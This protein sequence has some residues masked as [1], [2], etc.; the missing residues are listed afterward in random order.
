MFISLDLM[1]L[2][3][4]TK[5]HVN[6]YLVI[7]L[8]DT[9][10]IWKFCKSPLLS[11]LR[12]LGYVLLRCILIFRSPPCWLL[13]LWLPLFAIPPSHGACSL[14]PNLCH[15]KIQVGCMFSN[16]VM[17][18]NYGATIEPRA[19]LWSA[20]TWLCCWVHAGIEVVSY[21]PLQNYTD[22]LFSHEFF[23]GYLSLSYLKI[24]TSNQM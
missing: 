21:D 19:S 2:L 22:V 15:M 13:T 20:G 14:Q 8:V 17:S 5:S 9:R 16:G 3:G 6:P 10:R 7:T 4:K 12:Q 24:Y 18:S 1:L 23:L 11:C